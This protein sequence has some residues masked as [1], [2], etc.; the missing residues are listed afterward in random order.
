MTKMDFIEICLS[1]IIP[2]LIGIYFLGYTT[3]ITIY[4]VCFSIVQFY[5]IYLLDRETKAMLAKMRE[6]DKKE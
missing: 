3:A 1:L 4:L 5:E 2:L 6:L